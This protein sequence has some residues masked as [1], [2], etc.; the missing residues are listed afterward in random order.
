MLVIEDNRDVAST[1]EHVL[2]LMDQEVEVAFDGTSGLEAARRF[3]PDVVLCDLGLPDLDGYQVARQ[4][5][6]DAVLRATQL[7]ALS[8]YGQPEDRKRSAEAGFNQH[9][10]KPA[11][12]EELARVLGARAHDVHEAR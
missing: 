10:V 7:V 1:L 9:L 6:A 5:R 8:G 11:T 12:P 4:L 2:R 3:R